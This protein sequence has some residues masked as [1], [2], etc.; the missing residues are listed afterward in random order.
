MESLI[1]WFL[2]KPYSSTKT[3]HLLLPPH[4]H[5]HVITDQ[6]IGS[7]VWCKCVNVLIDTVYLLHW[8]FHNFHFLRKN[9]FITL[10]FTSVW[11]N[12]TQ[13]F[14]ELS[15]GRGLIYA[16]DYSPLLNNGKLYLVLAYFSSLQNQEILYRYSLFA[17]A[18]AEK[19]NT[20]KHRH[21]GLFHKDA[22][23]CTGVLSKSVKL[24]LRTMQDTI[25]RK[26]CKTFCRLC[27]V[28]CRC[29]K[30]LMLTC[31]EWF[32]QAF[33]CYYAMVMYFPSGFQFYDN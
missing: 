20:K 6:V 1:L 23:M 12:N 24:H 8:G 18:H 17:C 2:R 29:G 9:I 27:A 4:V 7:N 30:R 3:H 10:T 14:G 31:I 16:D 5:T 26:T 28:Q 33:A 22:C 15:L 13:C 11:G 32:F 19:E 25:V 21:E